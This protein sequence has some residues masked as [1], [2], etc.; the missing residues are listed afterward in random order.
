VKNNIQI[1][2]FAIRYNNHN[3]QKKVMKKNLPLELLEK[4]QPILDVQKRYIKKVLFFFLC[5][6]FIQPAFCQTIYLNGGITYSNIKWIEN[7]D[8]LN[9]Y[10]EFRIPIINYAVSAGAEF[11]NTKT[12]SFLPEIS[13]YSSSAKRSD[14]EQ[15]YPSPVNPN[16][17]PLGDLTVPVSFQYL[18]FDCLVSFNTWTIN[19]KVK[20]QLQA[21]PRF[22]FIVGNDLNKI[23]VPYTFPFN[24]FTKGNFGVTGAM[25][26]YYQ[27]KKFQAGIKANYLW[28]VNDVINM[29]IRDANSN[30]YMPYKKLVV[31]DNP[32][33]FSISVGYSLK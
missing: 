9:P 16:G 11:Q 3:F 30:P 20:V 14:R 12:V 2:L 18:S 32:I 10:Q 19:K 6:C 13:F 15:S 17:R 29:D 26:I 4:L 8:D 21:G 31:T 5:A 1:I 25:G 23:F 27:I 24:D 33:L 28:R 22:D 7:P